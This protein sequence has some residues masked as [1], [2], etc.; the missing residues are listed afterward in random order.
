MLGFVN[1]KKKSPIKK[2]PPTWNIFYKMRTF[3]KI[4]CISK[5]LLE[6]TLHMWFVYVLIL[7]NIEVKNNFKFDI[8]YALFIM[9]TLHWTWQQCHFGSST[10]DKPQTHM[11]C[12]ENTSLNLYY[13]TIEI[14]ACWLCV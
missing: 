3:E 11:F 1:L 12:I 4:A 10:L 2:I 5:N 8:I 7:I 14:F 6:Y 13:H 9:A